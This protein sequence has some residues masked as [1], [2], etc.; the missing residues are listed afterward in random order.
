MGRTVRGATVSVCGAC[1]AELQVGQWPFCPHEEASGRVIAAATTER[2]VVWQNAQTG[3]VR[4]PGRNDVPI[5]ERY[6]KQGFERR[7]M[8]TLASLRR[9]ENERGVVNEAAHWDRGSGRGI[10]E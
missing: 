4:Y 7:E 6:A 9:F 5:P 3:E 10:C 8:P 2:C 1:G